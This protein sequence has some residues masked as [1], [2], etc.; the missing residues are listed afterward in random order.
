MKLYIKNNIHILSIILL[1]ACSLILWF[2]KI[3]IDKIF[4]V[5]PVITKDILV[6]SC[7]Y[8]PVLFLII[9]AKR[10]KTDI[11]TIFVL[12]TFSLM[13]INTT[14]SH[15][16]EYNSKWFFMGSAILYFY[17]KRK[18][19]KPSIETYAMAIYFTV[20]AIS[21]VWTIDKT[22]GATI[23]D[24]YLP[25]ITLPIFFS[26]ISLN[27]E[28][29]DKILQVFVRAM[30]IY[31]CFSIINWISEAQIQQTNL[32]DWIVVGKKPINGNYVYN[33]IFSWTSYPHPTYNS[34][35]YLFAL[36]GAFY[37]FTKQESRFKISTLEL[38]SYL[39]LTGTL[40]IITQTRIGLIAYGT[41][42]SVG[43]GKIIWQLKQNWIKYA[44]VG[45]IALVITIGGI[46]QR[47][48]IDSFLNDPVREQ[49]LK[50]A[51]VSI[52]EKPILGHGVGSTRKIMDDEELAKKIGY[53]YANIGLANPH[54]QF[55]G[56]MMQ[57]GIIGLINLCILIGI[58][59]Y[60][61]IKNKNWLYVM[62][63][64]L[65]LLI[66]NIE[67]PLIMPKGINYFVVICMFLSMYNR[68][69]KK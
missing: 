69:N 23:I 39:I 12:T 45:A 49:N 52:K 55:L 54:H 2:N 22:E 46:S 37:L 48:K 36:I 17:K 59:T 56:D 20:L 14:L 38:I 34:I 58:I 21:Y 6:A 67:M 29:L 15:R 41:I 50:T 61:S 51:I 25:F 11:E 68:E 63:I 57:A 28:Q 44:Y 53:P 1:I 30:S 7:V 60:S 64:I 65:F 33:L 42:V 5:I 3:E 10:N 47:N 16:A 18:F 31:M 24:D 27:K 26:I 8:I 9:D 43:L 4:S 35:G 62:F 66:M 13:L 32:L 40:V 19:I